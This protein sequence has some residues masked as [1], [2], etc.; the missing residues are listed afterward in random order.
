VKRIVAYPERCTACRTCELACALAHV[1]TDDLAE[2]IRRGAKPRIYIEPAGP[3]AVPL[4]CRHCDDAPCI[5]VCPTGALW[6]AGEAEPVLVNQQRCIGCEFCVQA[7]P[8]GVIVLRKSAVPG[9]PDGVR[10][11]IKCDLCQTRLSQGLQPA[12]VSSCPVA[13]LGFEEVDEQARRARTTTAART[14]TAENLQPARDDP[15][16]RQA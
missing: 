10:A 4:Q 8:F 2:A 16:V 5:T 6:R 14:A 1:G 15:R 3:L 7:C 13:A 12:C 9:A 11:V